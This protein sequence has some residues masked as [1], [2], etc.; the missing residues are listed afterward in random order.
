[1]YGSS[2]T[3]LTLATATPVSIGAAFAVG[4]WSMA[5]VTLFFLCAALFQLVRPGLSTRP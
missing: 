2:G 3:G 1:M 4:W 5:A